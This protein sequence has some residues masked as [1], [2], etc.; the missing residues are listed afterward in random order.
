MWAMMAK[1]KYPSTPIETVVVIEVSPMVAPATRPVAASD[2][3][4][5][6][7]HHQSLRKLTARSHWLMNFGGLID[8]SASP[9]RTA[10]KR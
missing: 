7:A 4:P 2:L 1:M 9:A 8:I 5:M 6:S 3:I 10:A